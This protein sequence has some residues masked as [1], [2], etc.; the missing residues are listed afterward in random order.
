MVA[1]A[2]ATRLPLVTTPALLLAADH[3]AEPA[4]PTSALAV[5][6]AAEDRLLSG[7]D[8]VAPAT[9]PGAPH[10]STPESGPPVT[11]PPSSGPG[12]SAT[13]VP[14]A[15]VTPSGS[16]LPPAN[17]VYNIPPAPDFLWSCSELGVDESTGCTDAALD[18][19]DHGRA[20]EGLPP[21]VLPTQWAALSPARQL[22]VVTNLERTV[23]GLPPLA[24]ESAQ[25]DQAAGV[26]AV[27]GND[28]TPPVG[29]PVMHWGAN[30]AGEI[31]N[32][33][34]V[35]YFWMYDDGPGSP[36]V[37]CGP[38]TGSQCWG[39]RDNVLLALSCQSCL[40]GVAVD[41]SGWAGTPA[42]SEILADTSPGQPTL[43]TWADVIAGRAD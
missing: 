35:M 33:L 39:H 38:G 26:G 21:M 37:T 22:F 14:G 12:A 25:L 2:L 27:T 19:I 28:A 16:L 31:G 15:A 4:R 34:E 42:W 13:T 8:R 1:L 32:P 7:S 9:T 36:N 29:F 23:R 17:P 5:G 43:F 24:G 30:W 10:R 20:L 18:A 40:I 11:V 41:P 6:T 3:G